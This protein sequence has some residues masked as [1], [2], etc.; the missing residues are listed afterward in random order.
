MLF[1]LTLQDIS[2]SM[3]AIGHLFCIIIVQ[4][5]NCVNI[6]LNVDPQ[7]ISRLYT[8]CI[9]LDKNLITYH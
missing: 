4:L 7:I 1:P 8:I 3:E 2:L 9:V 5:A 6:Y